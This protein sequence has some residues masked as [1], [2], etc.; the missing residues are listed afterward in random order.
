MFAELTINEF[1]DIEEGN[2]DTIITLIYKRS[3][4]IFDNKS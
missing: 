3:G 2:E 4:K 1:I